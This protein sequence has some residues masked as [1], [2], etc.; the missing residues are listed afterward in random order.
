MSKITREEILKRAHE[1]RASEGITNIDKA[2]MFLICEGKTSKEIGAA[3][4]KGQRTIEGYRR[5]I[6]I[7]TNS[8]N[9]VGIVIYAIRN[10]IYLL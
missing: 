9:N 8:R 7:K 10:G 5:Y 1:K 4:G 3:L 6:L 2:I